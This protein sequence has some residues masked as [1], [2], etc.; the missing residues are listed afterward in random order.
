MTDAF[1]SAGE[2]LDWCIAHPK[3]AAQVMLDAVQRAEL[4]LRTLQATKRWA[5]VIGP[6][7][8]YGYWQY[9][10]AVMLDQCVGVVGRDAEGYSVAIRFCNSRRFSSDPRRENWWEQPWHGQVLLIG[11]R[12]HLGTM[13][14][15]KC[16]RK[17]LG[18]HVIVPDELRGTDDASIAQ[19][20][21]VY[22]SSP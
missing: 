2:F 12:L 15:G 14:P 3:E 22:D 19:D 10:G 11:K 5:A 20:R 8:I 9:I 6:P 7:K 16:R 13:L 18:T 21:R 1:M 17:V 4:E